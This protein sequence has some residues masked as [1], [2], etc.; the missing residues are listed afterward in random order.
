MSAL[1]VQLNREGPRSLEAPRE[2]SAHRPFE[3]V[4]QNHGEGLHA[5]LSLDEELSRVARLAD[6]NAFVPGGERERVRVDTASVDAPVTGTLTISIGYG[7][8]TREV[9]VTVVPFDE[10]E[11]RVQV[12]ETL[13]RPQ[14]TAPN[15][16]LVSRLPDAQAIAL[17]GLAGVAVLVA[18][19][20]AVFV[21]STVVTVG[22]LVV[23]VAVLA[24]VA[25]AVR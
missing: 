2:F 12:D 19:A 14:R 17:L 22:A 18:L 10:G 4:F 21:P 3:V 24:A 11:E 20:A 16:G 23:V 9:A 5:H 7:A 1:D 25:L 15:S 6:G 8:T 13:A